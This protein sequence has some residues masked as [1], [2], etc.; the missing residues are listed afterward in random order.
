[1][2][3][4]RFVVA[5]IAALLLAACASARVLPEPAAAPLA[6]ARAAAP[7][8]VVALDGRLLRPPQTIPGRERLEADLAAARARRDAHPG[9]PDAWIWLGRRLG[10]LW[11]YQEAIAVFD[12]GLRRW[13]DDARLLRHRGH[14]LIT[15]RDFASAQADLERAAALVA[16]RPDQVEP[17]G[18]PNPAGVP[19]TSLAYNIGYHLGLARYLQDDLAGAAAAWRDTLAVAGNDDAV[20]AATDWLWIATMRLGRTQ[21]AA[22]LL[23]AIAPDM[24]ILENHSY[25]QRLLMYRGLRTAQSLLDEA[26]D[27]IALATQGYGV[28]NWH[29]VHGRRS[30][31]LAVFDAVLAGPGWNAFGSIAA[32]ADRQRLR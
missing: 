4:P 17:D 31:A 32:E 2:S 18:A 7:A 29:L 26:G 23:L 13:P 12:E 30:Q 1:M 25:H 8:P 5:L 11:R 20:V 22:Q 24:D 21:D 15:V 10:Y 27:G 14:R 16:G 9:D 19:R 3:R 28:G 6:A